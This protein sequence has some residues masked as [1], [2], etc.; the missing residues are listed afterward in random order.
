MNMYN[1]TG[2]KL[3]GAMLIFVMMLGVLAQASTMWQLEPAVKGQYDAIIAEILKRIRSP[4]FLVLDE[5]S[6]G[7]KRTINVSAAIQDPL[8]QVYEANKAQGDQDYS[9]VYDRFVTEPCSE[10]L[11]LDRRLRE[12]VRK[13]PQSDD[14]VTHVRKDLPPFYSDTVRLCQQEHDTKQAKGQALY[15]QIVSR[16]KQSIEGAEYS[17]LSGAVRLIKQ[18]NSLGPSKA[19]ARPLAD[20][21]RAQRK[22][23]CR[24]PTTFNDIYSI[25]VEQPCKKSVDFAAELNECLDQYPQIDDLSYS[26]ERLPEL[27][28][29]V[30]EI[31]LMIEEEGR[32]HIEAQ[33]QIM[34]RY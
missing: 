32:D 1:S 10:F 29:E 9:K 2:S 13:N 24:K 21:Y 28:G 31:C 20:V 5:A 14:Y 7:F 8:S 19:L 18:S 17:V 16:I 33:F 11:A 23:G 34:K 4:R 22:K 15:D 27:Y 30:M 12:F 25:Y 3:F 26:Y 6:R